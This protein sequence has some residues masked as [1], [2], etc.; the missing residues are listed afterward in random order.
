MR[1]NDFATG[2]LSPDITFLID[3][4]SSVGLQRL[5]TS[6]RQLD[7]FEREQGGR[8]NAA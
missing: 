8:G 4:D 2:G 1:L 3:V 5:T 6:E 7:R